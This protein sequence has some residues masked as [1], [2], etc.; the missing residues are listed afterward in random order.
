M[1]ER[2][3]AEAAGR[4]AKDEA[5]LHAPGELPL[6]VSAK[7][8]A[9]MQRILRA[10]ALLESLSQR[11]ARGR[12][13]N[14]GDMTVLYILERSEGRVDI[15]GV[16]LQ[17]AL[18]NT[19]GAITKRLDR[20]QAAGLVARAPAPNDGR[21]VLVALTPAGKAFL[22]RTRAAQPSRL[23]ERIGDLLSE[24]EWDV[25]HELLERIIATLERRAAD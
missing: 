25:M 8:M 14:P 19:S 2:R 13:V 9:S 16:D 18:M 22:V 4:H 6:P 23:S 12:Q 3:N 1:G 5:A 17:R 20:L 11:A 21:A 15:R 24:Q 7:P 10:A